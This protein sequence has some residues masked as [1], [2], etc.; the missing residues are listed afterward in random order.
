MDKSIKFGTDGWRGIIAE[1][2]TFDNVRA[3]AQG[4]ADYLRDAGGADRGLVVGYDTR[5]ASE[6]FAAA[7]AE[8]SAGN[9][10]RCL[11]GTRPAPTPVISYSIVDRGAA[12]AVIITASHNPGAWNGLKYKP[13]YA[14]SASP[15]VVSELEERIAGVLKSGNVK[16]EPLGKGR[17]QGLIEIC[18][19]EPAYSRQVASLLDLE[20]VRKAGLNVVVD[21][22]YGS[23]AGYLARLLHGGSAR[24]AEI[25]SERNPLFP[26]IQPEPIGKNLTKLCS[27]V[28]ETGADVG[29]AT[30]GDADRIGVVDEQGRFIT[31]LQVFA[32][33][34]LYLLEVRGERGPIVKSVTTTDMV[35]RLG[36][37]FSVPVHE[38]AVGFKYLGPR[39]M[40]ENALIGGEESGGYGFRGHIPERDGVLAGLFM[41]DL[42]VSTGKKPSE[43][44]SYLYEKVGP[45]Y[46]DRIDT[47]FPP[48]RREAVVKRLREARPSEVAGAKVS[49]MDNVDGFRYRLESGG[50]LLIRLSG[51]EPLLRIYAESDSMERVQQVLARGK[52]LAGI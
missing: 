26:G 1:D 30:D 2:F 49:G 46:Y 6:D 10:I 25:N 32:L 29:L 47:H 22:M 11:L 7:V 5:F 50:W 41:L 35:Y 27:T 44:I 18:D 34:V 20:R 19:P 24:V 31:T 17:E 13:D 51:T 16:R 23:G 21:S 39:M 43:L 14:G 28:V 48:E 33:L 40:Q 3:C 36:D 8:V 4:I 12:G 37:I 45:H 42:M 52:D 9:G 38:T 15:E